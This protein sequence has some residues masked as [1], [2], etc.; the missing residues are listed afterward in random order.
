[1][2]VN[3]EECEQASLGDGDVVTLGGV[4]FKLRL[5]A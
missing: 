1:M 5:A 2:L 3:G 4:S